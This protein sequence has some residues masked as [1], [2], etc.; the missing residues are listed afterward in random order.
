MLVCDGVLVGGS[1]A[2]EHARLLLPPLSGRVD[3]GGAA[4]AR[5]YLTSR[6][7]TS[8]KLITLVAIDPSSKLAIDPIPRVPIAI[9]PQPRSRAQRTMFQPDHLHGPR[10]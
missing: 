5:R 8:A 4:R 2:G 9:R 10:H 1:S 6:T 7:G 3:R